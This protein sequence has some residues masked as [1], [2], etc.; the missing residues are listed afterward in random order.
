MANKTYLQ[1]VNDVMVRLREPEVTAVTDNAYSK[2]IGKFVNDAKRQVEDSFNWNALRTTQAVTTSS[3]VYS[4]SLTD[5]EQRFRVLYVLN[6]G[7]DWFLGYKTRTEMA[8]LIFN[9]PL[10]S[11]SPEYYSFNGV[12][13]NGDTK[14]DLYPVPDGVYT[15]NFEVVKPQA[16][17]SA[18]ADQLKVPSE[19]VIFLAYSKALNERGEDNG[20]NSTE[21]YQLYRQS[22]ADHIA[23][24][25]GR[26][27]EDLIWTSY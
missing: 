6:S 8:D 10:V 4:Y 25:D 21:A 20:V 11:G 16:E 27:E 9:Q 24:A 23:I 22:L 19:P 5:C 14:V 2:L 3:S 15:I 1:L 26:Q 18:S 13:S 17:L 7:D 12:D